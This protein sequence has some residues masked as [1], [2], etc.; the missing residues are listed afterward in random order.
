MSCKLALA[1]LVLTGA[2]TALA[3]TVAT[4]PAAHASTYLLDFTSSGGDVGALKLTFSGTTAVSASG[5]IDGDAVKGLSPYASADQQLFVLGPV[6]FTIGGLSFAATNGTLYNLTSY[7]N[8][9]DGITNSVRDPGGYGSPAPYTL[10]TLSIS[11]VPLPASW[12]L[13]LLALGALGFAVR[14][15]RGTMR[16]AA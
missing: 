14:S 5:T 10:T 1:G 13:M 3:V 7:P 8:N 9:F 4:T 16:T 2:V 6:H 11:Q 12:G 15:R